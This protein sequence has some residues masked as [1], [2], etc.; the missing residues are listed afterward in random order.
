MRYARFCYSGPQKAKPWDLKASLSRT[1]VAANLELWPRSGGAGREFLRAGGRYASIPILS[2][3]P[4][5]ATISQR[6]GSAVKW[7]ID[8]LV[9]QLDRVAASEAAGRWF[10]SS[11]ARHSPI[12]PSNRLKIARPG[13]RTGASQRVS[14]PRKPIQNKD[15]E[16]AAGV[17][18]PPR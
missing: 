1:V 3:P 18:S 8:A 14:A 10:E 6:R 12:A 17:T 5:L 2:P 15:M 11:R 7:Q 13:Q 16:R 4:T 9:A